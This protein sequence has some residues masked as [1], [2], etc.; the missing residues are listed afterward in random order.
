MAAGYRS[1]SVAGLDPRKQLRIAAVASAF[2]AAQSHFWKEPEPERD[3][4]ISLL[5][6]FLDWLIDQAPCVE[7]TGR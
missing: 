3:W 7:E 5:T 6:R 1:P 2:K 4:D